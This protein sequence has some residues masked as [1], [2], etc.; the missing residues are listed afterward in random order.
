MGKLSYSFILLLMSTLSST[1][2]A[3]N[4]E[5]QINPEIVCH[6]LS[7]EQKKRSFSLSKK[8]MQLSKHFYK[9]LNFSPFF[10]V[11]KLLNPPKMRAELTTPFQGD[12]THLSVK[13]EDGETI[14][15]TYFNRNS[16]TLLVVGTG[17]GNERE[18]VAPFVHMFSQ[19]DVIIF[20]YRGHGY[21][22]P[23]L[24]DVTKWR[25]SPTS[26]LKNLVKILTPFLDWSRV[27]NID[28]NKT[29]LGKKEDK[30]LL[31]VINHMCTTK[32]YKKLFGIGLCFSSHIFAKTASQQPELFDKLIL[33][34][35]LYSMQ[36]LMNRISNSPQLIL[37]PQRGQWPGGMNSLVKGEKNKETP[38]SGTTILSKMFIGTPSSENDTTAA[39]LST[40][41]TETSVL[42][43]HGNQDIMTPYE[44]DF[45]A[46]LKESKL[47]NK[48]GIT[49]EKGR[50][51]TNHI[52]YKEAY[53]CLGNLFFEL[54]FETFIDHIKHPEK[55]A[56]HR[57]N[58]IVKLVN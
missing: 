22:Q 28:L 23:S 56:Q 44:T 45:L 40:L 20:D 38:T 43:F 41:P 15:C 50:H 4:N 32:E 33:D 10:N 46:N 37:D 51:L 12:G 17:F 35:S 2:Y 47:C 24:L 8:F 1:T 30:D 3:A 31:A 53:A 16:D 39:Y 48:L 19:Y 54:P 49:F 5:Q 26:F 55:I 18:K 7:P 52:K 13:T 29:T 34:S 57:A 42:F 9:N 27:P 58:E 25:F 36:K 6:E 21:D 11:K 14:S